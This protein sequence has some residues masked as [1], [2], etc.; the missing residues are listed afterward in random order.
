[1]SLVPVAWCR[2]R[3]GEAGERDRSW[4]GGGNGVPSIAETVGQA[5]EQTIKTEVSSAFAAYFSA[6][7]ASSETNQVSSCTV[8]HQD[9]HT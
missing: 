7:N 6:S 2:G 8:L 1:M 5:G 4:G 3:R 9:T